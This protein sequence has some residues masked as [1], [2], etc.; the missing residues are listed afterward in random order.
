MR[1]TIRFFATF[2]LIALIL[3]LIVPTGGAL[4]Q[5]D[6]PTDITAT[7]K[8][9]LRLRSGPGTSYA[10]LGTVPHNTVLPV[11]GRNED[12]NWL[13]VEYNGSRGWI[14]GWHT[15]IAGVLSR[16]PVVDAEG[17]GVAVL[18]EQASASTGLVAKPRVNLRM[19]SGPGTGFRQVGS[20]PSGVTVPV[21]EE[22][23][24]GQ[25]LRVQYSGTVGWIAG[26]L[27]D[28]ESVVTTALSGEPLA[29]ASA[30]EPEGEMATVTRVIDGDTIEVMMNGRSYRVR[31][32]GVNAPETDQ[33]CG[34]EA[35]QANRIM[36]SGQRVRLVKDV[37]ETDQFGRL[38]RYVY[39]G[40]WMVNAQLVADG[41]AQ[42]ATY[43][44]DV[45][46][47]DHFNLLTAQ[48]RAANRGCWGLGAWADSP[49]PAGEQPPAPEGGAPCDCSG[50][51]YN[52]SNFRSHSEAQTCFEYC[53]SVRGYDVHRL[54][55]DNDGLACE[56]LP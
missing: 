35:T 40:D 46:H 12:S 13:F 20:V 43:P 5:T 16:V 18:A 44:P 22:S 19:R 39:V 3:S 33:V 45:R 48:A 51:L 54:D 41:W 26:W 50:N 56:S 27:A 42:A 55:G 49:A 10:I 31:Y 38:L 32:I 11:L 6:A 1:R 21:L 37:S 15:N 28:T 14:A 7:T 9:N 29:L 2:I 30:P 52:C 8:V 23:T 4:A 36:V 25:W 53:L 34:T 47:A 17:S 24:D